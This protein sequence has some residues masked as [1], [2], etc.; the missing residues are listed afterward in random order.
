LTPHRRVEWPEVTLGGPQEPYIDRVVSDEPLLRGPKLVVAYGTVSGIEWTLT[1]FHTRPVGD[2]RT[3]DRPVGPELEFFL[4]RQGEEG[5][6]RAY[7][8]IPQGKHVSLSGHFFG[9]LPHIVAWVGVVA[10]DV[11][12]IEARAADAD[13]RTADLMQAP[14]GFPDCFLLFP[15]QDVDTDILAMSASG[16]VLES[17]R[18]RRMSDLPPNANAGTTINGV[19]WMEGERPPG[20][21]DHP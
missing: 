12:S 7:A 8:Q 9:R 3:N 5:G 15:P 2:W 11:N 6:G 4:G 18:L 13:I 19:S 20:W 10:V 17:H 16:E 21:A 14:P 1:A